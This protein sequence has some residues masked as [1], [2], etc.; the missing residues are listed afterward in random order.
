MKGDEEEG[1]AKNPTNVTRKVGM[2]RIFWFIVLWDWAF[3]HRLLLFM[4][5]L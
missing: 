4:F 5:G 3:L 1:L 2:W